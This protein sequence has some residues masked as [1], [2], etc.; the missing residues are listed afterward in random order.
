VAPTADRCGH[1]RGPASTLC[2]SIAAVPLVATSAK[3]C[4]LTC[5]SDAQCRSKSLLPDRAAAVTT[6]W[7]KVRLQEIVTDESR[8]DGR[9]PRT[10]ECELTD[11]LVDKCIPGDEVGLV[12]SAVCARTPGACTAPLGPRQT[13]LRCQE[14]LSQLC[15]LR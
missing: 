7:Q 2:C 6:D 4:W 3:W 11:D 5:C 13:A 1:P 12:S 10:I 9:M 8:E 14:A 15:I